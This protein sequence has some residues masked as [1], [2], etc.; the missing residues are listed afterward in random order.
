VSELL[1]YAFAAEN[2]KYKGL[3]RL[4]EFRRRSEKI[5][6]FRSKSQS[7]CSY[8]SPINFALSR[9]TSTGSLFIG[10]VISE[11]EGGNRASR[12]V[13]S[14]RACWKREVCLRSSPPVS[15]QARLAPAPAFA[16]RSIANDRPRPRWSR[17]EIDTA[18]W[19]C[20]SPAAPPSS[21][22]A[23]SSS[24]RAPTGWYFPDMIR[25]VLCVA[26]DRSLLSSCRSWARLGGYDP[27]RDTSYGR[28]VP[29]PAN[30]SR[31]L[32]SFLSP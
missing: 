27:M 4:Q 8:R 26:T 14:T 15:S 21:A 28:L 31:A 1:R 16:T 17:V 29:T 9:L 10:K 20:S 2:Y 25:G 12:Y 30:I 6:Y 32:I 11:E 13:D 3:D 18:G 23:F 22:P 7:G 24:Y 5:K 19:C